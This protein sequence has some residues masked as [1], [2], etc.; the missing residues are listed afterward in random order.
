[1]DEIKL[2]EGG[3]REH[4]FYHNSRIIKVHMWSPIAAQWQ[5]NRLTTFCNVAVSK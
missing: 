5:D 3:S 1:M 4:I 2:S